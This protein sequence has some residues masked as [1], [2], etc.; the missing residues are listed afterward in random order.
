MDESNM[1]MIDVT[2]LIIDELGGLTSAVG[3]VLV[4]DP[5]L[6]HDATNPNKAIMVVVL[7]TGL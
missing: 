1:M 6:P 2:P 5:P 7:I 3:T 4:F